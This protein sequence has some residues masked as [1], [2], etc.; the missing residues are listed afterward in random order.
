VKD[1]IDAPENQYK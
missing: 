1:H